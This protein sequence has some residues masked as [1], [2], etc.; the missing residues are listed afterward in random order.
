MDNTT[1]GNTSL[2]QGGG[3]L[4]G[5]PRGGLKGAADREGACVPDLPGDLETGGQKSGAPEDTASKHKVG[6]TG[7][8]EL[9]E[10]F[11]GRQASTGQGIGR[12]YRNPHGVGPTSGGVEAPHTLVQ[13][14]VR[15][16]IPTVT[17]T[18]GKIATKRVDL[19]RCRPPEG[20]RVPILV[21]LVVVEYG[22]PGEEEVT[23]AVPSLKICRSGGPL[24]MRAKD[25]KEWLREASR[26]TDLVTHRWRLL[27]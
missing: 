21:T 11:E 10:S 3:N 18:I 24:D 2:D 15:G 25:L 14:S 19:F 27:V 22:I 5:Y 13:E 4:R 23:Q 16:P 8:T 20:L 6:Q 9:P 12:V 7:A 1:K 17:R 26:K